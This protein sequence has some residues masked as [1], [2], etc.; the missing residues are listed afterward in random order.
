[1]E[2]YKIEARTRA[3]LDS[4]DE[5]VDEVTG[6]VS[7]DF[8]DRLDALDI[9]VMYKI[10]SIGVVL[11][12]LKGDIAT[13]RDERHRLEARELSM[14]KRKDWLVNYVSSTMRALDITKHRSPSGWFTVWLQKG[15][16]KVEVE[17]PGALPKVFQ[18]VTVE[19][20]KKDIKA[21]WDKGQLDKEVIDLAGIELITGEKKVR[22]K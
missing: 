4:M 19:A 14:N 18:R 20:K 5:H 3:L 9:E 11:R 15:P 21:A 6:E 16:D 12:E 8:Y 1:M 10:E 13:V 7:P 22:Y 17:R 2:L